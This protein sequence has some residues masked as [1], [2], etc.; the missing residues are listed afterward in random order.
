[1]TLFVQKA[2]KSE[3]EAAIRAHGGNVQAI[4]RALECTPKTVYNT[5]DRYG[6]RGDLKAARDQ[7]PVIPLR[8]MVILRTRMLERAVEILHGALCGTL[9]M[10]DARAIAE[11]RADLD[12]FSG[13]LID[14]IVRKIAE[15]ARD[16]VLP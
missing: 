7:A 5:L 14:D 3:M 9:H 8:D 11:M 12:A 16:E 10:E 13:Q 6:M 2:T 4:A 15:R 1:M